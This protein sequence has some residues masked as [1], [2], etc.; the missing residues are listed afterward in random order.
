VSTIVAFDETEVTTDP[1]RLLEFQDGGIWMARAVGEPLGAQNLTLSAFSRVNQDSPLRLAAAATINGPT[2][3][4][5]ATLEVGPVYSSELLDLWAVLSTGTPV[6]I[7][8]IVEQLARLRTVQQGR[9]L[10]TGGVDSL[11]T[12]PYGG[13]F[14]LLVDVGVMESGDNL[15]LRLKTAG[16]GPGSTV[17]VDKYAML[18]DAQDQ[19]IYFLGPCFARTS[20]EPTLEQ[21]AGDPRTYDWKVVLVE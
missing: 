19:G 8:W 1:T 17:V 20:F 5:P 12:V 9:L 16:A 13:K 18:Q 2:P 4:D 21:S 10:A 14:G 3:N 6:T 15:E 11:V 7:P